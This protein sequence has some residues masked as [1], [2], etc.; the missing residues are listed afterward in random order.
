MNITATLIGQTITFAL[1][2]WFCMKYIWPPIVTALEARRKQ[3]ADGLAAADRG[4]H[5]LELAA[6][7][8]SETLHEAKLKA[9]EIISQAEKRANEIVD[10]AKNDAKA[11]GERQ[12]VAAQAEIEQEAFRAREQ[13]REQ[14]AALVLAGAE[15]VL[16]REVNAQAHADL[17]ETIKNEL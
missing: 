14:V 2:V 16:R 9:V 17:L 5:E 8:A 4:K 3:I 11:E 13:L 6:K 1:F 7:R 15:K 12:L 10:E